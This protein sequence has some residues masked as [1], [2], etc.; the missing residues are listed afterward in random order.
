LSVEIEN[1][2]KDIR[3]RPET[4]SMMS[5]AWI[6]A[7]VLPIVLV[8]T[9]VVAF[10]V[11]FISAIATF[12]TTPPG[13]PPSF[14]LPFALFALIPL[15]YLIAIA[16]IIINVML[17][18]RLI[19]RR[20]THFKRQTFL[21]ED[22][23]AS[24]KT[25]SAKKTADVEVSSASMDRTLREAK[26]EETEKS[27]VLWALLSVFVPFVSWYVYYFLMKDFYRH[28]RGED[29]FWEDMSKTLDKLGIKF[30]L[31]RRTEP[32]PDRSFF[33]YL[34]V[35]IITGGIFGIYWM[36]VLLKDPNNHFGHHIQVEEPLLSTLEAALT[37]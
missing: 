5:A 14:S 36:Y 1:V 11:A 32:I 35:T 33:L 27:A 24:I 21:F 30:S 13:Q 31:P 22:V 12:S 16:S 6:L 3:M 19:K 28:E 2:R 34:I 37:T 17:M 9:W 29:G 25:A 18:Y 4:D 10:F 20:N 7:Y 15:L 8:L 23:L 26:I